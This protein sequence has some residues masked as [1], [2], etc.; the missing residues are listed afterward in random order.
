MYK[1]YEQLA[2]LALNEHF[3]NMSEKSVIVMLFWGFLFIHVLK[4]YLE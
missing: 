4:Q 3:S 1:V 2:N